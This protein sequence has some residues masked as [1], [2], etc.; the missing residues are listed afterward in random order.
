MLGWPAMVCTV[1]SL[2]APDRV[3]LPLGIVVGLGLMAVVVTGSI[4]LGVAAK[5]AR[6]TTF[7]ASLAIVVAVV[8][9]SLMATS[10]FIAREQ[11]A[12]PSPPNLV[13]GFLQRTGGG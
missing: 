6:E 12:L 11:P 5:A 1:L 2:P 13:P 8:G 9:C 7:A 10:P 3:W 4:A